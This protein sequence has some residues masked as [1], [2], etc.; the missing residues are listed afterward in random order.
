MRVVGERARRRRVRRDALPDG[1]EDRHAA[2]RHAA[3]GDGPHPLR[4]R[5]PGDAEHGRRGPLPSRRHDGAGRGASGRTGD[6]RQSSTADFF[7]DGVRDDAQYLRDLYNIERVEALKGSNAMI[8][9][10]GGGGGVINQ[11]RRE[12]PWSQV[13][14]LTLEG[15]SFDHKRGTLDVGGPLGEHVA[16]RLDGVYEKSRGF[17]DAA[18]LS[19]PRRHADGDDRRGGNV[20]RS[21]TSSS[22]TTAPSI[23]AFRRSAVSRRRRRSRRS[24]VIRP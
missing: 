1:D 22:T 17:R 13:G 7:V 10:R 15:G 19:R 20:I 6:P 23:A 14:S 21:T 24:S 8:F 2:P 16:A 3:V 12:A 9:G 11:V 4:H 18:R 5:R